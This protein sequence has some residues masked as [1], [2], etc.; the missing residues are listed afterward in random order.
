MTD[1]VLTGAYGGDFDV[2]LE[3][4]AAFFRVVATGRRELAEEG[5]GGDAD[6]E[7]AV[8]NDRAGADLAV[9]AQL[10]RKGALT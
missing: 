3:R 8:R 6:R 4:A 7:L 5:T 9:A 10:W 1:A 2:A